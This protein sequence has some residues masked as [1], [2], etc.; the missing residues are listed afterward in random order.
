M[1]KILGVFTDMHGKLGNAV[2]QTWKGI[3]V[4][5]THVIPAN[6]QSAGQTINRTLLTNLVNMFKGIVVPFVRVYWNPFCTAKC[7]GWGNLIGLNQGL[8]HGTVIDYELVR[9]THGSLPGED[10]LTM[11]YTTIGGEVAVTWVDSGAGGSA[12]TDLAMLGVYNK[13]TGRW[14]FSS[15]AATRTDAADAVT[16]P[17]GLVVTDLTGYLFFFTAHAVTGVVESTSDSK[18]Q[19]TV[20]P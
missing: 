1:A 15:A 2:L 4:I 17:E 13:D 9:I 14:F 5:R 7:T 8:Q 16:I 3:Q 20:A 10:I 6:P 19:E 11:T 12:P 18:A